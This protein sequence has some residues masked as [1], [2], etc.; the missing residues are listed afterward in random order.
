MR[1]RATIVNEDPSSHRTLRN[2]LLSDPEVEF[3]TNDRWPVGIADAI[4]HGSP[5]LLFLNVATTITATDCLALVNAYQSGCLPVA[6]LVGPHLKPATE[7]FDA[8][9]FGYLAVPASQDRLAEVLHEAKTYICGQSLLERERGLQAWVASPGNLTRKPDRIIIRSAG[10][11]V[12][13]RAVEIEWIEADGNNVRVHV[14]KDSYTQRKTISAMERELDPATFSRI[15][16]SAIVNLDRI[17]EIRPWSTGEYVVLMRNGKEL[18]LSRGYRARL[19]LLLGGTEAIEK[20]DE[21]T[22]S[23][24]ANTGSC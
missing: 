6:I 18:T 13:V 21:S 22:L 10:R 5:D 19:P 20:M 15:H 1:I 24:K 2:M 16:R 23:S 17:R 11:F 8:Q 4:K 12:F 14:G 3:V 9:G 7:A